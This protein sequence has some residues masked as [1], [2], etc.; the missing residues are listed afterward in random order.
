MLS[1]LVTA[2]A[3]P[4]P[5]IRRRKALTLWAW[6]PAPWAPSMARELLDLIDRVRVAEATLARLKAERS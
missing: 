6:W 5:V 3:A 2:I 4:V 1:F